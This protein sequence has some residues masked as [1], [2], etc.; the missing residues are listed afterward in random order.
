MTCFARRHYKL[1]KRP[2]SRWFYKFVQHRQ[3]TNAP[4]D[5]YSLQDQITKAGDETQP[6]TAEG[7]RE[8]SQSLTNREV[9][10][11]SNAAFPSI[12]HF[13][14]KAF[15]RVLSVNVQFLILPSPVG[16]VCKQNAD[17]RI[18][19]RRNTPR[20]SVAWLSLPERRPKVAM[21]TGD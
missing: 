5:S 3:Q 13:C 15:A 14:T 16:G 19:F 18:N 4:H 17:L 6:R 21:E 10:A 11:A 12:S 7:K 2:K 20:V 1:S 9:K 8:G